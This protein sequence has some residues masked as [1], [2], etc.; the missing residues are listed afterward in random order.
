MKWKISISNGNLMFFSFFVALKLRLRRLVKSVSP[1][2]RRQRATGPLILRR[3]TFKGN[4]S[5]HPDLGGFDLPTLRREWSAPIVP[6]PCSW[7]LRPGLIDMK[8]SSEEKPEC[9]LRMCPEHSQGHHSKPHPAPPPRLCVG[10]EAAINK[11]H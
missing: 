7:F 6:A 1:A 10:E 9:L 2:V 8:S 11:Y 3:S 4:K 5:A